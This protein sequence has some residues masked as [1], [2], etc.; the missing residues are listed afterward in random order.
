MA[1]GNISP[2]TSPSNRALQPPPSV[3][4]PNPMDLFASQGLSSPTPS[5]PM[6]APTAEAPDLLDPFDFAP[7]AYSQEKAPQISP[8]KALVF[9]KN[10][11]KIELDRAAGDSEFHLVFRNSL[12]IPLEN[13]LFQAAVPKVRGTC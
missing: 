5:S 8:G 7:P 11:L 6:P 3:P 1:L 13:L 9:D 12:P 10:G 2:S 4:A